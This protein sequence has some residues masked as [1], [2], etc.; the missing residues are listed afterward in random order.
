MS[1]SLLDLK[2]ELSNEIFGMTSNKAKDDGIC[3]SC[4]NHIFIHPY[5]TFDYAPLPT[6]EEKSKPGIIYSSMGLKEYEISGLCE[7]C[8]DKTALEE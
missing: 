7:Y 4:K 1:K 5:V 6:N 8:F 3:I 2:A